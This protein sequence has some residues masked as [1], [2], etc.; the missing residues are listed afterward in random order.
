MVLQSAKIILRCLH[1][2]KY[3]S[4]FISVAFTHNVPKNRPKSGSLCSLNFFPECKQDFYLVSSAGNGSAAICSRCPDKTHSFPGDDGIEG[5]SKSNKQHYSKHDCSPVEQSVWCPR[6]D[7]LNVYSTPN[8][9]SR[10][11]IWTT[12]AIRVLHECWYISESQENKNNLQTNNNCVLYVDIL[13][14]GCSQGFYLMISAGDLSAGDFFA[15][16]YEACPDNTAVLVS[17]PSFNETDWYSK[18]AEIKEICLYNDVSHLQA[19][20]L[21]WSKLFKPINLEVLEGLIS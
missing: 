5:C 2:S 11:I 20:Y 3:I 6:Q 18:S 15:A 12:W 17:E 1:T 4:N 10:G 16:T 19:V 13:F 8:A 21:R 7:V 14:P 9:N